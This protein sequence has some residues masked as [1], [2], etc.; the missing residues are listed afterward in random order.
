MRKQT[1]LLLTPPNLLP[2]IYILNGPT[3][4]G[5]SYGLNLKWYEILCTADKG[6]QF[7]L[8]GNTAESIYKNVISDLLKFDTCGDLN[9]TKNPSLISTRNGAICFCVGV[10]NDGGEKRTQ[11]G[12]VK[13][14]YIDEVTTIARSPFD[15]IMARARWVVDGKLQE[16]P[17]FMTCNAGSPSHYIKREYIDMPEKG[18]VVEYYDFWDNPVMSQEYIDALKK[19]FTGVF[20]ERM[21]MNKWV[22]AEGVVYNM[23][24]RRTHIIDKWPDDIDQYI[25]GVDWGYE[26]P[27]AILLIGIDSDN[28]Y[29][30]L[31]EIYTSK[32]LI[33][34]SLFNLLHKKGWYNLK[35]KYK[36]VRPESAYCDSARPEYIYQFHQLCG[37]TSF[38]ANKE[39]NEGI[40]H[41]SI[42]LTDK[43]NGKKSLYVLNTCVKTIME[44]ESYSW[45][46]DRSGESV[47]TVIKENDHAMDALRYAIHTHERNRVKTIDKSNLF[48]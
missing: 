19:K 28:T 38:Q 23:F 45:K 24:D 16:M 2:K 42:K 31:D 11:G 29:Y 43:G 40:Q 13:A 35:T 33:D 12:S 9:Y 36:T 27:L 3:G 26:N 48:M 30:V 21:V 32:Q 37:I 17:V 4:S 46:R 10:N 15:Q 7:I 1:K 25:L 20:F 5:K 6:D 22:S 44:F 39:V 18:A 47:D 41:V 14:A 8:A 34:K